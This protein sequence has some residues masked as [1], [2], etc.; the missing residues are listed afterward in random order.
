MADSGWIYSGS[1]RE[2][3]IRIRVW[4]GQEDPDNNRTYCYAQSILESY[5]S[6][7]FNARSNNHFG[8]DGSTNNVVNDNGVYYST[9]GVSEIQL[10]WWEGWVGHDIAGNRYFS[11]HSDFDVLGSGQVWDVN[12]IA[13]DAGTWLPDYDRRPVPP[14]NMGISRDNNGTR[15]RITGNSYPQHNGPAIDYYRIYGSSDGG[16]S[17]PLMWDLGSGNS[18]DTYLNNY[19]FAPTTTYY[20]HVYAHNADNFSYTHSGVFGIHGAPSQPNVP[21]ISTHQTNDNSVNVSWSA[22]SSNLT[23]TQYDLYRS[24]TATPIKTLTGNPA[25]TSWVD[26]TAQSGEQY[27][28]KVYAYNSSGWSA[29][30][31][32]SATATVSGPPATPS[33]IYL[34]YSGRNATVSVDPSPNFYNIPINYQDQNQGYFVQYQ[35]SSSPSGPYGDWS[36]AIRMS[37]Q[38]TRTHRFELLSPALYYKFRVYAANSIVNN[39]DGAKTYYPNNGGTLANSIET[40][41]VFLSAGG[42]RYRS[43][44]EPL[45]GTFQPTETAKRWDSDTNNWVA[46]NTA[47]RWDPALNNNAGGWATLT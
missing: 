22:P 4:T 8:I 11:A 46:L 40:S 42:R 36:T 3:R 15:I 27:T 26:N 20:F 6:T 38:A 17:W 32:N 39:K 18:I 35:T 14:Y 19:S 44:G 31:N 47:K 33:Q 45:E 25:S 10:G 30:S 16:S 29:S 23:I 5:G 2:H 7:S 41:S 34:T 9:V 37:D 21:T 24:G 28:Y 43:P 1:S 13:A 12:Y